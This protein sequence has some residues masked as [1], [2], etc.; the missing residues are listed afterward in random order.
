MD[1]RVRD[2]IHG[3]ICLRERQAKLIGTRPFQRL[4]GIRQLAMANLV[5]PGAVHS[6]FDHTLGVAHVAGL[7]AEALGFDSDQIELIQFAALLHDVGHGPFS[8]VSEHALE[9]YADRTKLAPDQKKEKIHEIITSRMIREHAAIQHILGGDTCEQVVKLLGQGRGPPALRS[10]I[11]GPLD[12][13]K[14][15]YLLRDSYFCGVKYGVFDIHQMHRSLKLMGNP[16]EEQLMIAPDGIHAIEQFVLAK[17]YLTTNVYRHRVR[18]I[19]D[20]MIVRAIVLGIDQDGN[21]VLRKLYAFDDSDAFVQEYLN[22]DDARFLLTFGGSTETQCGKLLSRLQQRQLLKQVFKANVADLSDDVR[23]V[24][25]DLG[26]LH[27]FDLRRGI[28]ARIAERIAT[29]L[30]QPIDANQVILHAF[31][32]KSVREASRNDEAGIFVAAPSG[33]RLFE[34][35]SQLFRSINEGYVAQ[36]VEVYAPVE[37]DTPADKNRLRRGWREPITEL[38]E[39]GCRENMDGARP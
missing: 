38:I 30:S 25:M 19:T 5:Y 9:R 16:D 11:S 28:E 7:M 18:L 29:S 22:W 27:R 24:V 2:P 32:I 17:Y 14:Q 36:F 4:R 10:V 6:R 20:Q 34:E 3:F 26:K 13:D 12:A 35:E 21:D 31:D 33:P 1:V 8:H 37:W 23:E 39:S 15:D